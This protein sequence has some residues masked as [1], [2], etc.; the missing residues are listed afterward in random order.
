MTAATTHAEVHALCLQR[1]RLGL[2]LREGQI[3]AVERPLVAVIG[4][5]AVAVLALV[6]GQLAI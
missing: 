5:F 3:G 4:A 2:A 6:L 1:E